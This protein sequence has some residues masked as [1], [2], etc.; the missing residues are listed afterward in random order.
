MG[1][2]FPESTSVAI[3]AGLHAM[4]TQKQEIK[5]LTQLVSLLLYFS[6]Y[7]KFATLYA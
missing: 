1:L 4:K 7:L 6:R 5:Y 2:S 3:D